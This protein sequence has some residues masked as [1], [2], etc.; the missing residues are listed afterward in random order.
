M[1]SRAHF[2]HVPPGTQE[3]YNSFSSENSIT[4]KAKE[5]IQP[6][7]PGGGKGEPG[8]PPTHFLYQRAWLCLL[9]VLIYL[10]NND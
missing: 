8:V 3:N 4:E 2:Q 6:E 1:A 7:G 5:I 10:S 9:R